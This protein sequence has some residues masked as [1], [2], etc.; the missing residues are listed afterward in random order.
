MIHA[1]TELGSGRRRERVDSDYT[2]RLAAAV[3]ATLHA[4]WHRRSLNVCNGDSIAAP[5]TMRC[6]R[7]TMRPAIPRVSLWGRQLLEFA[8]RGL[9][10]AGPLP[11]GKN[12]GLQLVR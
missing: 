3:G 10:G 9:I 12:C 4:G 11:S 2:I 7:S 6:G 8:A 1:S 5:A